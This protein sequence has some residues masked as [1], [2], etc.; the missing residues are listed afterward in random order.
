M[1]TTRASLPGHG[2]ASSPATARAYLYG[3]TVALT[4][5]CSAF[6]IVSSRAC[7]P[8]STTPPVMIV[9]ADTQGEAGYD[10]LAPAE[11][12]RRSSTSLANTLSRSD[13]DTAGSGCDSSHSLSHGSLALSLPG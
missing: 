8:C 7:P 13:A 11:A 9:H 6:S 5:A 3:A 12:D 2:C 10:C 4:M 1:T